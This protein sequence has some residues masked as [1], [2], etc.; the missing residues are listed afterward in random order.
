MW[1]C[2]IF[3]LDV[4]LAIVFFDAQLLI[5]MPTPDVDARIAWSH[6]HTD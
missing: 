6:S 3:S 1:E 2:S 5:L 4:C